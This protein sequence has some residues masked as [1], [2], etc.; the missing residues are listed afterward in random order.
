MTRAV[1]RR[2]T[3]RGRADA[4]EVGGDGVAV[5]EDAFGLAGHAVALLGELGEHLGVGDREVDLAGAVEAGEDLLDD[6]DGD[7]GVEEAADLAD[8][9][10]GGLGEVAVAVGGAV[11][12]DEAVLL[13][14]AEHPGGGAGA[15]RQ[16]ADPHVGRLTHAGL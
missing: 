3:G 1:R 12:G 8:A 11:G 14:V 15:L 2:F 6:L 10:D 5:L 7:A 13:V 9:F 16:F 4:V